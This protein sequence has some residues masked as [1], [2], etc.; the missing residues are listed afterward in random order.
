MLFIFQIRVICGLLVYD[1][2]DSRKLY[3][4]IDSGSTDKKED[5][6]DVD[7]I[8]RLFISSLSSIYSTRA[9]TIGDTSPNSFANSVNVSLP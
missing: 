6:K 7:Q 4:N 5:K 3:I 8:P 1:F 2:S 9:P